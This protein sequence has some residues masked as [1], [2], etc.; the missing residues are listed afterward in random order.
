MQ[1]TLEH[2]KQWNIEEWPTFSHEE[3][4]NTKCDGLY[5]SAFSRE[6]ELNGCVHIK[7][8]YVYTHVSIS[9]YRE[10]VI[11]IGVIIDI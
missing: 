7:L 5:S 1:E 11:F 10:R 9:I 4:K 8:Y 2:G 3:S 6:T